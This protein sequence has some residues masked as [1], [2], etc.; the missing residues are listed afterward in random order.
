MISTKVG[1][2]YKWNVGIVH[3]CAASDSFQFSFPKQIEKLFYV[4]ILPK[5][6]GIFAQNDNSKLKTILS[7]D[8][9]EFWPK[10]EA[11]I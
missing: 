6:S 7:L 10:T 8:S 5:I 1:P 3:P 2:W 4:G 9:W 11:F